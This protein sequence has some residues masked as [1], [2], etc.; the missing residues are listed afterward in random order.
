MALWLMIG[1]LILAFIDKHLLPLTVCCNSY[2]LHT[3]VCAIRYKRTRHGISFFDLAR[4]DIYMLAAA[5]RLALG[6]ISSC[7]LAETVLAGV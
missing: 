7:D 6:G 3:T 4:T 1:Q 2:S 5:S